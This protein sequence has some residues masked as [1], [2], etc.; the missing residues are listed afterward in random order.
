MATTS[1]RPAATGCSYS[2]TG[3]TGTAPP[4]PPILPELALVI[5]RLDEMSN[6]V[7]VDAPWAG[8]QRRRIRLQTLEN[9]ISGNGVNPQFQELDVGLDAADLR[10]RAARAVASLHALLHRRRRRTRRTRALSSALQHPDGAQKSRFH[11]GSQLIA[12]GW[13]SGYGRAMR[14]RQR[15]CG[16]SAQAAAASSVRPTR[17]D[18]RGEAG[19]RRDSASRWPG[20]STTR[21]LLPA[22]ASS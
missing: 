3:P 13:R 21:P 19:D 10:R 14:A 20:G 9:W 22:S 4:D 12:S 16:A 7:P 17:L 6:E 8:P 11:G 15:R 18:V 1:N 2:D 5:T